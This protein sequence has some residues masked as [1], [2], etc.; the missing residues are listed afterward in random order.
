MILSQ[1]SA[2]QLFP[3]SSAT[4]IPAGT[5]VSTTSSNYY[6]L[7]TES[8]TLSSSYHN[9]NI[10]LNDLLTEDTAVENL[11]PLISDITNWP[12]VVRVASGVA[13]IKVSHRNVSQ[14]LSLDMKTLSG[15]G[16][17]LNVTGFVAATVG[18]HSWGIL[19]PLL[20][21][22]GDLSLLSGGVHSG[23]NW[24]FSGASYNSACWAADFDFSGVT[25]NQSAWN[26][27]H[28]CGTAITE[29]HLLFAAHY[30]P[31][32]GATVTFI[33]PDG[34]NVT[35][36]IL[37]YNSGTAPGS[38][39]LNASNVVNDLAVAVLSGPD[40]STDGIAVYPVVGPWIRKDDI[41]D[42][43]GRD[44]FVQ[45]W[46]GLKLDQN[47]KVLLAGRADTH[48]LTIQPQSG[49]YNGVE[50]ADLNTFVITDVGPP[51]YLPQFLAAYS[52]FYTQSITGDSGT[53]RFFP[54]T[55]STMALVGCVTYGSGGASFPDEGVLNACIASAD[56]AAGIAT[57]YT[58]TVA[59]NPTL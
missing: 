47:R 9:Y 38:G 21:A 53:P 55:A 24:H 23:G 45:A 17:T 41:Q 31:P 1:R 51:M 2:N 22:G 57:G 4:P 46:V 13:T 42:A 16:T 14:R 50:F 29:R 32:V 37:A 56:S 3:V 12:L 18:D 39:Q 52:A 33:A 36:T 40:L 5:E 19:D 15:G 49:T 59:P 58:V 27:P 34:S 26:T 25:H 54:I 20:V 35:R 44:A 10:V 48:P 11:T 7:T 28:M 8:V 30:C 43:S 6:D